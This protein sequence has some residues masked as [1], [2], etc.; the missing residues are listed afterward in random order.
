M[1]LSFLL[2][3]TLSS[4]FYQFSPALPNTKLDAINKL[5]MGVLEKVTMVFEN[6]FWSG[7]GVM[8][9][10]FDDTDIPYFDSFDEI[11][12]HPTLIAWYGGSRATEISNSYTDDEMLVLKCLEELSEVFE[13][14][15][16]TPLE[17]YVSH[18]QQDE[19]AFGSYAYIPVG[20]AK[21]EDMD[22]LAEEVKNV[23][24]AGEATTPD[25]YGQVSVFSILYFIIFDY[26]I[27]APF[28]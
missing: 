26:L 22:I 11:Y 6:K 27:T 23:Y 13:T 19:Y 1:R 9:V 28:Q 5:E 20:G 4:L 12:E 17:T 14:E 24:F 3:L 16:P 8:Y 10:S 7:E 18:W 25:Y 15:I 21:P 2:F